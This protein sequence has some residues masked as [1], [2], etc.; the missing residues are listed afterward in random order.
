MNIQ[1]R[2]CDFIRLMAAMTVTL[3]VASPAAAQW[4][5]GMGWGMFGVGPSPST[6]LLN[7]HAVTR[8]AAGG[9]R[10]PSRSPLSGNSNSYVNRVRDNGFVSHY[11]VARRAAPSYRSTSAAAR[12]SAGRS[13]GGSV[14]SNTP[15]ASVTPLASFFD[16]SLRLI[17]PNESPVDGELQGKRDVSD[18]AGRAVLMETKQHGPASLASVTDARQKLLDYGRPALREIRARATPAIADSFHGFLLS[19]YDSLAAAGPSL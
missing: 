10:A 16:A 5:M 2:L 8:A 19:L 13:Q 18:D 7:Q 3:G 4:G 1:R 15:A 11:D 9:S 6:Q 14:A 17:W 12:S